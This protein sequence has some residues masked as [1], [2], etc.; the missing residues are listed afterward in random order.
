LLEDGYLRSEYLGMNILSLFESKQPSMI[1]IDIG[2]SSIRLLELDKDNSGY[3]IKAYYRENIP[4]NVLDGKSI[5]EP[6]ALVELVKQALKKGKI[7]TKKAVVAVPDSTVIS[8]IIQ[9][10]EGLTDDEAEELV[11]LE[12]DKYI[13]YPIEEVSIDYQ[14]IGPSARGGSLQDVLVVASRS[15]NVSSRVQLLKQCGLDVS[16]V[17]VESYAIERCCQLFKNSLIKEG[18][19]TNIA[20]F[21]IGEMISHLTVLSDMRTAFSRDEVFGGQQLTSEMVSHYGMSVEEAREAKKQSNLPSDFQEVVL[22]P[23][24]ELVSMQIRRSLQFF[25]STSQHHEVDQ[26]LLAGG[27]SLLPGMV[28]KVEETIEVPTTLVSPL[29]GMKFAKSVDEAA[30]KQDASGIML[31]CGLAMRKFK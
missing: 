25:F 4:D 7:K 10:E 11:L 30:L 26:I 23:F 27:T 15:E 16:I 17:D 31:A 8:K 14:F 19:G 28:E 24:L 9:L 6:E 5:K 3:T 2:S 22:E 18:E 12:A 1:G 29:D 13:P 21:D 20:I